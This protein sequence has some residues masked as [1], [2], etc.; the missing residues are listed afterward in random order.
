MAR[1]GTLMPLQKRIAL[2]PADYFFYSHDRM[3]RRRREGGNIAFMQMELDG[4]VDPARLQDALRRTFEKH[5]VLIARQRLSWL[6]GSPYWRLPTAPDRAA[7]DAARRAYQY[8]DLRSAPDGAAQADALLAQR[9]RPD[10]IHPRGPQMHVEHYA[11]PAG[12]TRICIRWPHLFMDAEGAM[13]FLT[14]LM[15]LDAGAPDKAE[16]STS[17]LHEDARLIDP[18]AGYGFIARARLAMQGLSAL[19]SPRENIGTLFD[20]EKPR[21]VD[22]RCI[23]RAWSGPQFDRFQQNAKRDASDGPA[24]YARFLAACTI[25]ALHEIFTSRGVTTD[26]YLITMPHSISRRAG[27]GTRP[28]QG[29]YLVSPTLRGPRTLVHDRAALTAEIGRQLAAYERADLATRQWALSWAASFARAGFYQVLMRLPLGFEALSSGFSYYRQLPALPRTLGGAS[30][31]NLWGAGP[32]P[33]PPAWNPTFS[34]Y[35]QTLNLSLTYARPAI[36]DA[37]AEQY[38]ACVER[39][40]LD[41][42]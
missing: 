8:D 14:E 4:H 40:I 10:W 37:L 17:G 22:Q 21:Y 25:R 2:N 12:Q 29:N 33:T 38:V 13:W 27:A 34:I 42:A 24:P 5:P 15:H 19:K 16:N 3:M 1:V 26:A 35:G 39:E 11:L 30:V 36:S 6:S 23:H 31:R 41:V 32:L 20:N 28:L 9:Y 7:P 18:L